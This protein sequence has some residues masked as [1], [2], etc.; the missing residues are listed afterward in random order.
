MSVQFK[1]NSIKVKEALNDAITAFLHEAAGELSSQVQR[2]TRVDTGQLKSS[3][4]Y[5]IDEGA[6]EATIGSGLENA[7]WEEFGT[8]EHALKGN[9]R[10]GGWVY[11]DRHGET[12]YT[13]GKTPSRAFFNAYTSSK[14][15]IIKRAKQVIGARMK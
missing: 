15:M 12:H 7:I 2:N 9:G 11:T 10:K 6:K 14:S 4:D 13:K 3:W 8:G 5:R 1:D